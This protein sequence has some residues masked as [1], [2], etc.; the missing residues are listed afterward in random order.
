MEILPKELKIRLNVQNYFTLIIKNNE[1]ETKSIKLIA[2]K[3]NVLSTSQGPVQANVELDKSQLEIKQGEISSVRVGIEASASSRHKSDEPRNHLELIVRADQ[4]EEYRV[5]IELDQEPESRRIYQEQADDQIPTTKE[6]PWKGKE[7]AAS[8][9]IFGGIL[10]DRV[11]ETESNFEQSES[12]SSFLEFK[13]KLET[14]KLENLKMVS[15]FEPNTVAENKKPEMLECYENLITGNQVL[16]HKLKTVAKGLQRK[17]SLIVDLGG[18]V[19][20]LESQL[21]HLRKRDQLLDEVEFL[22]ENESGSL[23]TVRSKYY[24]R[25]MQDQRL[26]NGENASV[27]DMQARVLEAHEKELAGYLEQREVVTWGRS[28]CSRDLFFMAD[29]GFFDL[30]GGP[31]R[32]SEARGESD[33]AGGRLEKEVSRLKEELSRH[34]L[35]ARKSEKVIQFLNTNNEKLENQLSEA[36][37]RELQLTGEMRQLALKSDKG[38]AKGARLGELRREITKL[39]DEMF[40]KNKDISE[41]LRTIENLEA[42]MGKLREEIEGLR[43]EKYRVEMEGKEELSELQQLVDKLESEEKNR[44]QGSQRE[45]E[46]RLGQAR[47]KEAELEE[48]EVRVTLRERAGRGRADPRLKCWMR[49]LRTLAESRSRGAVQQLGTKVETIQVRRVG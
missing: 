26:S 30:L 15:S 40:E 11:K 41:K 47:R 5:K 31:E 18:F 17:E 8:D 46:E 14:G 49:R 43:R 6:F 2:P 4:N 13:R 34:K 16:E 24:A 3:N 12:E 36:V 25:K 28:S 22:L 29:F 1:L 23:G 33:K 7:G 19:V 38:R 45:W 20:H 44:E 39:K 32:S 21:E 37:D 27:A 42:E 48:R 10:K 35:K 9:N